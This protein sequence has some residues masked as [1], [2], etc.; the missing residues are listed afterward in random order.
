M[1]TWRKYILYADE[2]K[3][4]S[5]RTNIDS[6]FTTLSCSGQFQNFFDVIDIMLDM[7]YHVNNPVVSIEF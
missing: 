7:N 1:K 5:I 6:M 4:A 2:T 3:I